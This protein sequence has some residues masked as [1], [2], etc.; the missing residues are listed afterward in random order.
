MSVR[1]VVDE[2]LHIG[3]DEPDLC[4]DLVGGRGPGERFR[5][6]VPGV[7]VV[8]DLLDQD[9]DAGECASADGLA[10]E[11]SEPNFD[12]VQPRGADGSE[13]EV[14]V[15]VLRQPLL[16]LGGGV[17]RK[18]VQD[19]MDVFPRMRLHCL[20]EEGQEILA[21][22]G[23]LALAEHLAGGHVQSGEQVCGAV[24]N[25][26]GR[27]LLARREGDRQHRLGPGQRLDLRLLV[28]RENLSSFDAVA[29]IVEVLYEADFYR[30][31]H[32]LIYSG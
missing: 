5:G 25:V 28:D 19:N 13:M 24:P 15:R 21:I 11:G 7:D 30:P 16:D 29:D 6:R 2:F 18:V 31:A 17:R 26:V 4:E 3:R 20:L 1:V 22:P 9:V 23:R 12:L 8:T 10:G 32:G 14:D 27:A